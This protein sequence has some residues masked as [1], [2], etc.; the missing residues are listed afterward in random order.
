MKMLASYLILLIPVI[1]LSSNPPAPGSADE[2]VTVPIDS[3]I[4]VLFAV[5]IL[6]GGYI[7]FKKK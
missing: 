2:L 1:A 3:M 4:S 7:I 6:F 5:G